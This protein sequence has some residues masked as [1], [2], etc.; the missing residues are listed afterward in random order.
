MADKLMHH[1]TW[2]DLKG[3]DVVPDTVHHVVCFVDPEAD[4][5]WRERAGQVGRT[6]GVHIHDLKKQSLGTS[7]ENM[8][9]AIKV[10]LGR[11]CGGCFIPLHSLTLS[12]DRGSC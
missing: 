12:S 8:S 4:S 9:E 7:P 6:D 10:T 5:R 2:V 1:P 11:I 3:Q